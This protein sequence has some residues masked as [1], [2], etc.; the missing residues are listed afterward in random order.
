MQEPH[1]KKHCSLNGINIVPHLFS[2]YLG[3]KHNILRHRAYLVNKEFIYLHGTLI[4]EDVQII[5][6]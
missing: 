3:R 1:I 4:L 6:N 5:N 2:Q